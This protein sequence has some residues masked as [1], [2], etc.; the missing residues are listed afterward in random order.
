MKPSFF[1]EAHEAI[2]SLSYQNKKE[3]FIFEGPRPQIKPSA[4]VICGM[5]GSGISGDIICN[6]SEYSGIRVPII[7]HK[8]YGTP[9]I[10]G[11]AYIFVSFSGETAETLNAFENALK[12]YPKNS[13][14]VATR[15]GKLLEKARK[16]K[17]FLNFFKTENLTPR[18]GIG[19]TTNAVFSLLCSFIPTAR[20]IRPLLFSSIPHKHYAVF[21]RQ[22]ARDMSGRD[23]LIYTDNDFT[24]VGKAWKMYCNESG[25]KFAFVSV[26]PE[27]NHN[28]IESFTKKSG[29]HYAMLCIENPDA[30]KEVKK[31]LSGNANARKK[32][33]NESVSNSPFWK[34]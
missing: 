11:A 33:R 1:K 17:V 34:K 26:I 10:P 5:G 28:E 25:K 13:I 7:V 12:N 3:D 9:K 30:E 4:I 18:E 14:A 19:Y 16:N 15:G 6:L 8:N 21:A 27:A 31:T 29:K 24:S 20:D 23:A 22:L 32:S 2:Q